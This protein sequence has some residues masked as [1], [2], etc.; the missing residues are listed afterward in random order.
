MYAKY[1]ETEQKLIDAFWP[2]ALTIIFA[3]GKIIPKTVTAG[4]DTVAVR[5]PKDEI[6]KRLIE[7]AGVPV[8]APSANISGRPSG[9]NIED[10][11][12]E[13]KNKVEYIIDEGPVEIG[14]ESTVVKVEDNV[15]HILRPGNIT[16]EQI[17]EL[18]LEVTIEK[19]VL[20]EHEEGEKV[21][22]PGMKYKHYAPETKCVLVYSEDETKLVE[23]VSRLINESNKEVLVLAKDSNLEKYDVANKIGM[24]DSLEEIGRNIFT[25]LRKV[26]EYDVNLVLIEGV[27]P[28][29]IGLAIMNRLIR[30]CE[31][32]YIEK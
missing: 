23:E 13:L 20:G 10:I 8:A 32:N 12:K 25:L 29:G 3:R 21:L 24:G 22:S 18:G 17:E 27:K 30:A 31:N 5:M 14:L 11:K 16:K 1:G 28:Q 2:G 19:Q 7:Y 15:V 26:D 6:A 4:L 9:T